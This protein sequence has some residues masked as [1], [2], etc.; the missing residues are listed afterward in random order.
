MER[1]S[2]RQWMW[3]GKPWQAFKNFAII[4]S[5]VVNIVLVLVL[6]LVLPLILP[7]VD[8]IAMPIVGGLDGSFQQMNEASIEQTI[9]V[10]DDLDIAFNLPLE[11]ETVV[12][13]TEDVALT[14]VPATFQLPGGGGAINGYVSLN[15]PAELALPV[16]LNLEVPVQQT[17][18]VVLEVPVTIP[19]A[20][21][22]LGPPFAT[23]QS[24]FGPLNDALEKLPGSNQELYE[25]LTA[26]EQ[27]PE[28]V[29][30]ET[31]AP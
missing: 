12:R 23:L 29:A 26:G 13:V 19:L 18:P 10:D 28:S 20:E 4:F 2:R 11:T 24:L 14:S 5:F 6:L 16:E 9:I 15:L 1:S 8:Q 31:A 21:T 27:M 22:Q 17:I 30:P 25:R 7:I 3:T